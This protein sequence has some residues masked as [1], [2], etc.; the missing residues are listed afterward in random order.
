MMTRDSQTQAAP[1]KREEVKSYLR[2]EAQRVGSGGKLP[3]VLELRG[4]LGVAKATVNSALE[5][6]EVEGI[7]RRRRGSGIFASEDISQKRIGLVFGGNVFEVGRSP[8]YSILLAR[9]LARAVSHGEKFSFYIDVPTEGGDPSFPAHQDLMDALAR[10]RL[11]G[12]LLVSRSSP[13]QEAWLRAQGVPL[14]SDSPRQGVT[15]HLPRL[16][17]TRGSS[18]WE[19]VPWRNRAVGASG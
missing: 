15:S 17:I 6:L 13:E 2:D 1:S 14:V 8:F 7:V 12:I 16:W 3:T 10:K 5:E 4:K 19:C 11:H 9:S 18:G